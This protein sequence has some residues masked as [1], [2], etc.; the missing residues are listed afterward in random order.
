MAKIYE[1]KED[2]ERDKLKE[3]SGRLW[4]NALVQS[5][6]AMGLAAASLVTEFIRREKPET[7]GGLR[8]VSGILAITGIVEQVRSWTIQGKARN[9]ELQTE[10]MGPETTIIPADVP[11]MDMNPKDCGCKIKPYKRLLGPRTLLEQ[12]EKQDV[13]AARE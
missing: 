6:T 5:G 2:F 7:R 1:T 13:A 4:Q 12:A 8:W 9:L 10:R 11:N 3:Q